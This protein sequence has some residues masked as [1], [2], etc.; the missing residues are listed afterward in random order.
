MKKRKFLSI[1]L[2]LALVFSMTS[3]FTCAVYAD[4]GDTNTDQQLEASE[5]L[6][7]AY[8]PVCPKSVKVNNI[9][10][11]K[12]QFIYADS[13]AAQNGVINTSKGYAYYNNGT[14]TLHNFELTNVE[15][16]S[17]ILYEATE[18]DTSN[19]LNIVL[20]G[21]NV[22]TM[23]D[24]DA[25][26][27]HTDF[28]AI[29]VGDLN[30][31]IS[32]KT[33]GASLKIKSNDGF[34]GSGEVIDVDSISALS[35][36]LLSGNLDITAGVNSGC[37]SNNNYY[38]YD[39]AIFTTYGDI[40]ISGGSLN[41]NKACNGLYASDAV[42][43]NG[44]IITIGDRNVEENTITG[45]AIYTY[46]DS[47]LIN[48]GTV[49]LNNING[50]GICSDNSVIIKGG[51]LNINNTGSNGIYVDYGDLILRNCTVSLCDAGDEGEYTGIYVDYGDAIIEN[52]SLSIIN[53]GWDGIS[54]YGSVNISDSVVN[55]TAKVD[56][57]WAESE[58]KVSNS[59]VK[60]LSKSEDKGN[61]AFYPTVTVAGN[62]I[63]FAGATEA[64]SKRV[65]DVN[66]KDYQFVH[67]YKDDVK[68]GAYISNIFDKILSLFGGSNSN[69]VF[70]NSFITKFISNIFKLI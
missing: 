59:D 37:D 40:V 18:E 16:H 42:K 48:G 34:Y 8:I 32:A 3:A 41:I 69:M 36:E 19:A 35:F 26:E 24:F 56:G 13:T 12:G 20:E 55:I 57:I 68:A 65:F 23:K 25:E 5:Q 46:Y 30:L 39:T 66:K 47:V 27:T 17:A 43:I 22:I 15:G 4:V 21:A 7:T 44:G 10:L 53:S 14:L 67:I 38:Y 61:F 33:A 29:D 1:L 70:L 64:T 28:D 45:N 9:A 60:V 2:T 6:D 51:S 31:T 63:V 11:E 52:S 50:Y 58:I 62:P 49:S 54:A